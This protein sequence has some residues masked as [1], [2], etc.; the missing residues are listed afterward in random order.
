MHTFHK[1][2]GIQMKKVSVLKKSLRAGITAVLDVRGTDFYSKASYLSDLLLGVMLR[3]LG[4]K[5]LLPGHLIFRDICVKAKYLEDSIF[6]IPAKSDALLCVMPYY[7]TLT[8]KIVKSLLKPGDVAID[9]GAHIG[10]YTIPM[11]KIVGSKGVI[12]AIEPSPIRKYLYKNIELNDVR[13]V[14]VSEKAAYSTQRRLELYFD[15]THCGIS[16]IMGN[17]ANKFVKS[18]P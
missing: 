10:V 6:C 8:F 2:V 12:V 5:N 15:L 7:E 13:N 16:S 11:A 17:W 1:T 14:V 3:R 4:A 9:V 18:K